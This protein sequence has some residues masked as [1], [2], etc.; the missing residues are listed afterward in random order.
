MDIETKTVGDVTVV[1]IS[2]ELDGKTSPEAQQ[3]ILPLM[4][5]GSKLLLD[6][7]QVGFMSSTGLRMMLLLYRQAA[8]S[9]SEIALVGLAEEIKDTMSATG[10]LEFFTVCDSVE[11]GVAALSS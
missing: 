11:D 2:G 9:D 7:T 6:M 3:T 4:E 8:A 10:F 5:E 1:E